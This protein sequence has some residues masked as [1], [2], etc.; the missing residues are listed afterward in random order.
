MKLAAAQ[1]PHSQLITKGPLLFIIAYSLAVLSPLILTRLMGFE[2]GNVK[3]ELAVGAGMIALMMLLSSFV[4]SGRFKSVAGKRGLDLTLKFHRRVAITALVFGVLHVAFIIRSSMPQHMELVAIPFLLIV[5][6]IVVARNHSRF[7]LKYEYW[8]LSHGVTAMLVVSAFTAHAVLEGSYSSH[9]ALTTYWLTLTVVAILSLFYVHNYV[10]LREAKHPYKIVELKNEAANQWTIT[11]EP[12]GFEA[13]NFEPGQYAFVSF[14]ESPFKDRPHPFSFSSCPSDRP[15]ISFTIKELG[16]FTNTVG[17]LKIGSNA[18][19]YGPYGHLSRNKPRGPDNKG[20]GLVLLAAGVGFTPMISMLREMRA[21]G[22]KDPV[23][24]LYACRNEEDILY[25]DELIKL[26]KELNM[27]LHIIL[28]TPSDN[29][30]GERGRLDRN[31][32]KKQIVFKQYH[33]YLYFI[34]G[35]TAFIKEAAKGLEEVGN[36]PVFNVIF[37]DFSTYS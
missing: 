36:I 35:T 16:D 8:R 33:E 23:K 17:E 27:D 22:D 31:Y 12:Q 11:I 10:P 14:G 25:K 1:V 37:E 7:R 6:L 21:K 30:Q 34:C 15:R 32:L 5:V 13:M 9:P 24:V 2:Q 26:S 4:L 28:S 18:F 3:R 29:W 19:L 20:L